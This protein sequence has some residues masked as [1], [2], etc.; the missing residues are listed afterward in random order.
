MDLI[1]Y[2]YIGKVLIADLSDKTYVIEDINA[3]WARD[4][5]GG[6]ALG[7]RYLYDLMP[8]NTPVF[9]PESVIGFVT[10]PVNG[11]RSFMGGRYVVVS[12][13]PVTGGFND[14]SSGG[15]FGPYL[16]RSGFDA[17][18]VKGISEKPVYIFID[19]DEVSFRDA[20]A[21]WGKTTLET[22]AALRAEIG[23][24]NICAA[25]IAPAGEHMSYMAAVMN[26]GHRAA[27]R[28]G[29][30]AV[31]GSKKLKA[32]VCRGN[33]KVPVKDPDTITEV[34]K[35]W[36][37]QAEGPSELLMSTWGVH[38]TAA[39]YESCAYMSDCGIK[40]WGGIP[41][42]LTE[43]QII[44]LS[45]VAM[46]AKYGAKKHA[47]DTCQVGC[48]AMYRLKS[49]KYDIETGRPEY[50][51][52]GAFGS[53]LLNGDS[54]SVNICNYLCNEYGYDT[55]SFGA[56]LAWVMECYD[57]GLFTLDELDGI[58]L[59]WGNAEAIIEMA[60]RICEY[61]GIGIALNNA[62]VKAAEHFGRGFEY[63]G[64]ASG[65]EIPHHCA[66]NNP[67]MARTFQYDA[68]PG[69]HVKG[70]RGAGFGFGPAEVK[71][72]YED[73]GEA[74]RAGVINAEFDNSSGFCH[75]CFFMER[76]AKFRYFDA[77]TGE[78]HTREDWDNIGLRAYT[79]RWAFNMREGMRKE[80]Y[81]I[82]PRNIGVP[83]LVGGPLDGIT[84][85]TKTLS[86]N[87]FEAMGWDADN[88]VPTLEFLEK[89]GG[90]DVVI[91]DLY[92]SG[93]WIGAGQH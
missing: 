45:G 54:D 32:V 77:V 21:L 56:T 6:A 62:T 85:D 86:D 79:I 5:M 91:K 4:F 42:D 93:V 68:T 20:S 80:D 33:H 14:T 66:R 9:A 69:R 48:G 88:A 31:M 27:G 10:G 15:K 64:T 16:R 49:G 52:L 50:E 22:E 90:L 71:Y 41:D 18:F 26:D 87:F 30:G 60:E 19:N 73:T 78:N 43:E 39:N 29:S 8:A 40:N 12:K 57:N 35:S 23:D 38:G 37:E 84:I 25:L 2:G 75:F 55:I 81:T 63:L 44:N 59:K 61:K 34:N 53:M 47:C 82:T 70:G 17:V 7:A 51:S 67:A 89:V 76:T 13:S 58:D 28:G 83:P 3:Q 72:I 65:I 74:D 11:T 36:K 46:D 92:P 24:D 1:M